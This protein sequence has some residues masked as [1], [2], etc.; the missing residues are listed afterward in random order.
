M[1]R[2]F[3]MLSLLCAPAFSSLQALA[4]QSSLWGS[5]AYGLSPVP[6]KIDSSSQTKTGGFG[7]GGD[8]A[9]QFFFPFYFGIVADYFPIYAESVVF[10]FAEFGTVD[11]KASLTATRVH[12]MLYLPIGEWIFTAD[13]AQAAPGTLRR[14]FRGFFATVTYGPNFF[15]VRA[16]VQSVET[17]NRAS[18]IGWSFGA[19]FVYEIYP[20]LSVRINAETMKI[21]EAE[22]SLWS[23]KAGLMYRVVF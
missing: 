16:E 14:F 15:R 3:L 19:G 1:K 4:V 23:A 9:V 18:R 21:L 8:L 5:F 12:G 2:I 7:G 6:E 17:I 11:V 22:I 20:Q 13:S 10:D